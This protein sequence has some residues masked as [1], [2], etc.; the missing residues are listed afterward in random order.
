MFV[1][2]NNI[3]FIKAGLLALVDLVHTICKF[4][5]EYQCDII[6]KNVTIINY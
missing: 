1:F 2:S 5:K 6:I 4:I 3:F